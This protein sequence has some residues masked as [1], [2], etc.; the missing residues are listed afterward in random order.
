MYQGIFALDGRLYFGWK[1]GTLRTRTFD[2]TNVRFSTDTRF[3]LY[4][5]VPRQST[6]FVDVPA[7]HHGR[8]LP[9]RKNSLV[10]VPARRE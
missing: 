3:P 7:S 5:V 6:T 10:L 2:G 4:L 9:E 8:L 1:N